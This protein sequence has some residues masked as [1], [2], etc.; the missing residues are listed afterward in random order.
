MSDKEKPAL[1][2]LSV[3]GAATTRY[4]RSVSSKSGSMY[5]E[6]TSNFKVFRLTTIYSPV[7][8]FMT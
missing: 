3:E 7:D 2:T 1:F 5:Y 6:T 8:L 4:C